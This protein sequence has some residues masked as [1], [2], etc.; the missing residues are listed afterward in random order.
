M[1]E[2][3]GSY[4]EGGGALVRVALALS[5]LTGQE[6]KVNNIRSGRAESGLKAQHLQAITALKKIGNAETNHLEI[7]STELH[8]IPGKIQKGT[9]EIDIGTAG[10][11]VLL[12]QALILPCLFAPGKITLKVKGGTCGKGQAPVEALQNILL[13]QLQ[14]FVQKMELKVL[15]Q[16]YYPK[17]GGEVQLEISPKNTAVSLPLLYQELAS[18]PIFNLTRPGTLEQIRGII[19]CSTDLTEKKIAERIQHSAKMALKRYT[20][21]V[22]IRMNYNQTLS[23]G[24]DIVLWAV[25]SHGQEVSSINPIILGSDAYLE[26]NKSSEQIGQEAAERLKKEIDSDAAVDRHVA[27]QLI[28]FM[29]LLPGSAIRASEIT[30]HTRTNIYIAEQFLPV[31]F[32]ILGNKISVQKRA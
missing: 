15:K 22:T 18:T 28:P 25:F 21:P 11:I 7:G 26:K 19:N 30:D 16:G 9:Y 14:R 29:A 8:F 10:S 27:D 12:L 4:L 24:G 5:A 31:K 20:V 17:G 32:N 2:L 23:T 3:D 1:I 13:P 6:F